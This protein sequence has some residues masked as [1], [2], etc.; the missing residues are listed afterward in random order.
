MSSKGYRDL[1][2]WQRGIELVKI[3]YNL[4]EKFPSKEM[5]ALTNQLQR[6]AVSV[7]SNIAEGKGRG[8]DKEFRRFLRISLGSLAEVDTQLE[9][10]RQLEYISELDFSETNQLVEEIRK[11]LYGLVNTVS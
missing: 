7:P 3:T 6:A 10:T 9:I 1:L 4:T 8:S 2:V 11:M 5:Y